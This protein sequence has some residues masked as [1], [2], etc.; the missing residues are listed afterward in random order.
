[1]A[2]TRSLNLTR[3]PGVAFCGTD[4]GSYDSA[5]APNGTFFG[6]AA[7][8]KLQETVSPGLRSDGAR[9]RFEREF[10]RVFL[11][12]RVLHESELSGLASDER[13]AGRRQHRCPA[14]TFVARMIG[15]LSGRE[16]IE[17]MVGVCAFAVIGLGH[18]RAAA[19]RGEELGVAGVRQKPA[20]VADAFHRRRAGEG[21]AWE[22][23]KRGS[24]ALPTLLIET[25]I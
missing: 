19:G 2:V 8:A 13:W 17:R 4:G 14:R 23:R 9:V 12:K 5:C 6:S 1:M 10:P 11:E 21:Q 16:T 25:L 18:L 3:S 20:D 22:V 15:D 24:N 7:S